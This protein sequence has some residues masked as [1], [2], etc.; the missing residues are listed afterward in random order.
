MQMVSRRKFG[1]FVEDWIRLAQKNG[2]AQRAKDD[3]KKNI[4]K[5]TAFKAR[6]QSEN[7]QMYSNSTVPYKRLSM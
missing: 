4:R 3:V 7:L 6:I 2:L 5:G 1:V